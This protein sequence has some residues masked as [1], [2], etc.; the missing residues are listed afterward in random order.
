MK[1]LLLFSKSG[2]YLA[3]SLN[4]DGFEFFFALIPLLSYAKSI[5]YAE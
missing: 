4:A 5:H 2:D 1:E 3:R